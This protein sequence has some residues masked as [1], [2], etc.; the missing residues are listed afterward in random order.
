M[1][2]IKV[3]S[4]KDIDLTFYNEGDILATEKDIYIILNGTLLKVTTTKPK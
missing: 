4:I 2:F 1:K 3:S